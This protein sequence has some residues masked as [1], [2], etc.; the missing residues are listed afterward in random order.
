M[1]KTQQADQPERDNDKAPD[2]CEAQ[3]HDFRF[4]IHPVS[5]TSL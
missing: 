1:V 2:D 3:M 5:M 4:F